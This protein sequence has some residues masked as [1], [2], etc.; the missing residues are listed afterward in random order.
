MTRHLLSFLPLLLLTKALAQ[1]TVQSPQPSVQVPLGQPAVLPCT[2]TLGSG[3]SPIHSFTLYPLSAA[4]AQLTVQSPQPSVQVPLGQPAVLPCTYTLG[5]GDSLRE[6]KWYERTMGGNRVPVVFYFTNPPQET[7]FRGYEGRASLVTADASTASL[8]LNETRFSDNGQFECLVGAM[9]S[10]VPQEVTANIDLRVLVAPH[11]PKITGDYS[12]ATGHLNLTCTALHGFPAANL[13]WYR[14]GLAVPAGRVDVVTDGQG[15]QDARV[16]VNFTVM[17][18]SSGAGTVTYRCDASHPALTTAMQASGKLG[19]PI[20]TGIT[21]SPANIESLMEYDDVTLTCAAEGGLVLEPTYRWSRDGTSLPDGAVAAGNTLKIVFASPKDSGTYRCTASNVLGSTNAK[22]TLQFKEQPLIREPQTQDESGLPGEITLVIVLAV[23]AGLGAF[24]GAA[25]YIRR[26]K[27]SQDEEAPE[28]VEEEPKPAVA[29]RS[30][31]KAPPV[32]MAQQRP[33]LTNQNV[34]PVASVD[35]GRPSHSNPR[36]EGAPS[37][38]Q[39]RG[40]DNPASKGDEF[41]PQY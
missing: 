24:G 41:N 11:A 21:T 17:A 7:A 16:S 30:I 9:V 34:P 37:G 8:R 33:S 19:P 2:Y 14:N 23:F 22:K 31:L 39:E 6:I 13:T 27:L 1:L 40:Y 5:S 20:V 38:V 10:G 35:Q 32:P 4:L 15:F 25:Y 29:P 12:E 28:V 18:N 3:D 36:P 26:R